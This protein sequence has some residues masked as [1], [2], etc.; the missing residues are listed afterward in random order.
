MSHWHNDT[1]TNPQI[2]N[3][4]ETRKM[5][6]WEW[7]TSKQ[8]LK[9]FATLRYHEHVTCVFKLSACRHFVNTICQ[10]KPLSKNWT[11]CSRT[12]SHKQCH[13]KCLPN[14]KMKFP[15][16]LHQ[17]HDIIVHLRPCDHK[18][19]RQKQGSS[20][21]CCEPHMCFPKSAYQRDFQMNVSRNFNVKFRKK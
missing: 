21:T 18:K 15:K 14:M 13:Q 19:S 7:H 6:R 1:F 11:I 20:C 8:L 9:G 4:T 10:D 5:F 12:I 3:T 16:G 2:S 17:R